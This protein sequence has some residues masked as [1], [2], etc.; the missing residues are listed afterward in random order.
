VAQLADLGD[1]YGISLW[2]LSLNALIFLGWKSA[3][4][5]KQLFAAAGVLFVV[6]MVYGF[7]RMA[8]WTPGWPVAV[9]AVQANTPV[10]D[11]WQM[12]AEDIADSYLKTSRPLIGTGTKL[13]VWPETA[14]PVPLRS[15][16]WLSEELHSFCDSGGMTLLTGATD[17][18]FDSARGVVPYNAAFMI[19]PSTRELWSSAKIHLVPFGERIPWQRTFPFLGKLHLGQAEWEPGKEV[20]VFPANNTIPPCGCL[21][22]FEVVFPDLAA[23]M[24]LK[25]ARILTTITNDGWYGNSSGPY[26]HLALA[27]LRAIATRRSIV[28]S[29][30][31]GISALIRPTGEL[32]KTLAFNR[33]GAIYGT[34][35]AQDE[36][37]LAV[38]LAHIW[39]WFYS[40]LLVLTLVVLWMKS[41]R[42]RTALSAA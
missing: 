21:I 38:R 36:I 27:Q 15:R 28:R 22:C 8:S 16:Q 29:A 14:T 42:R 10:E 5:R 32:E 4:R 26:Q 39:P 11:K 24:V 7:V 18:G 30:N 1:V 20:V 40:L 2:V 19:R 33:A 12:A 6:A 25:G 3:A 41:R 13:V 35:P 37:T 17:Y 9:G 23:D 31:T 34:L